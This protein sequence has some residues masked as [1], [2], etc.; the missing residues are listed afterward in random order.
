M[1]QRSS[2]AASQKAEASKQLESDSY[3]VSKEPEPKEQEGE[4]RERLQ[5]REASPEMA[6]EASSE[7]APGAGGAESG[8]GSKREVEEAESPPPAKKARP[9]PARQVLDFKAC[10]KKCRGRRL[11]LSLCCGI[12]ASPGYLDANSVEFDADPE[13]GKYH[14]QKVKEQKWEYPFNKL[15]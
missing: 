4:S 2:P 8:Q 13:P 9:C 6:P 10:V 15:V 7:V 5:G 3:E 11:L 14:M 1:K 12:R